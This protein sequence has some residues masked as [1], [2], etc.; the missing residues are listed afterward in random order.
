MLVAP[1]LRERVYYVA[2]ASEFKQAKGFCVP[3]APRESS[4][5]SILSIFLNGIGPRREALPTRFARDISGRVPFP[6]AAARTRS[7]PQPCVF[8]VVCSPYSR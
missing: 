8:R 1:W 7:F 6:Q 3:V 5:A 2:F 4:A